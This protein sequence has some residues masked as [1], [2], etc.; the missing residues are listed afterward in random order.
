MK[1]LLFTI[2]AIAV[3]ASLTVGL[4]SASASTRSSSA[5]K[6]AVARELARRGERTGDRRE[7]RPAS[8][9]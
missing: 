9:L 8:Q 2:A 1:S 6:V 4:G 5:A 3:G 7:K